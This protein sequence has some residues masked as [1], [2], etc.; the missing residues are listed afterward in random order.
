MWVTH[1]VCR[2]GEDLGRDGRGHLVHDVAEPVLLQR[3]VRVGLRGVVHG[4]LG[5]VGAAR[6]PGALGFSRLAGATQ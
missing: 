2:R 1:L 6:W 4:R 3:A 5:T